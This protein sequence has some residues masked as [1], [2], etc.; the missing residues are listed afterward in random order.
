MGGES[1]LSRIGRALLTLSA[2]FAVTACGSGSD[3]ERL[4]QEAGTGIPPLP[5]AKADAN[6]GANSP[7][8]SLSLAS[9]TEPGDPYERAVGCAVALNVLAVALEDM[10][11]L[12]GEAERT[13]LQRA[14]AIYERRAAAE[15]RRRELT[16]EEARATI[17]TRREQ[18]LDDPMPEV[19]RAAAC[20]RELT[21]T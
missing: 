1:Q 7:A 2:V 3:T 6:G 21:S 12:A 15:A 19:R 18:A 14:R 8:A 4:A 5:A 17:E 11:A 10:P 20:L 13:A 9:R 16:G